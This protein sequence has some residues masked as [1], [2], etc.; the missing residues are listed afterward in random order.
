[1]KSPGGVRV[2]PG[3]CLV[4]KKGFEAKWMYEKGAYQVYCSKQCSSFGLRAKNRENLARTRGS[5]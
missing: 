4:C 3:V 1:M 5:F 2:V